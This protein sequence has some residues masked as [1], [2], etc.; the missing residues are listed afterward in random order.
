[1]SKVGVICRIERGRYFVLTESGDFIMRK[2]TPPTDLALGDRINLSSSPVDLFGFRDKTR[3][4]PARSGWLRGVAVAAVLALAV[5]AS[6]QLL[7]LQSGSSSYFLAVDINPSLELEYDQHNQ[8]L[9]WRAYNQAGKDLLASLEKPDDVY[10]ALAAIFTRCVELELVQDEHDVFV[11]AA[12]EVPLD[13]ARLQGSFEGHGVAVQLHV[14]RLNKS[15]YKKDSGSPLRG[16]LNRKA[17]TQLDDSSPVAEA[18]LNNLTEELVSSI[19][20]VSWHSNPIVQ[21][22]VEKYLVSGKLV[23]DMISSNMTDEEIAWVLELAEA[24]QLSPSE[25]FQTLKAS[26]LPPGQFLKDYNKPEDVQAPDM[27]APGWLPEVLALESGHSAGQIS[28]YL[29]KGIS[30]DDLQVILA[31]ENL[32]E[33]KLEQLVKRLDSESIEVLSAEADSAKLAAE[34]QRIGLIIQQAAAW[35]DSQAV[36]DLAGAHKAREADVLYILGRGYGIDAAGDILVGKKAGQ[37]L[38]QVLDEAE[39]PGGGKPDQDKPGNSGN[40]GNSGNNKDKGKSN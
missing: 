25:I 16:Y 34:H 10:T 27:M 38:K 8:L 1:M 32:G 12:A 20:I 3:R 18:A 5:I 2:G 13:N 15:E 21:A 31:M 28:S 19:E 30:S 39:S 33:G 35:A 26:G 36:I 22:F 9:A 11:T 17:G 24:D 29:R 23:E 6:L 14:V 40:S 37:S 4:M 7:P